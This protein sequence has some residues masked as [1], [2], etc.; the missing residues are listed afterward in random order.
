MYANQL[1]IWIGFTPNNSNNFVTKSKESTTNNKIENIEKNYYY[2]KF[3]K[4]NG[5]FNQVG[6]CGIF[7]QNR[8]EKNKVK[9]SEWKERT[10][11][12]AP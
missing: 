9:I 5:K 7:D 6:E 10:W 2:N 12:N 8:T 1:F 11:L 4:K 3:K